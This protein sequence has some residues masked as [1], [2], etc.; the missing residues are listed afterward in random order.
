MLKSVIFIVFFTLF[1]ISCSQKEF[2][3][4]NPLG[5]AFGKPNDTDPLGIGLKPTLPSKDTSFP[6]PINSVS[7]Q[8]I[9]ALPLTNPKTHGSTFATPYSKPMLSSSPMQSAP[10]LA[11]MPDLFDRT[12]DFF[13]LMGANGVTITIWA[14]AAGNWLWGYSLNGSP[15]L[16]GLRIWRFVFLPSG[17]VMIL[18]FAT[19]TTCINTYGI[20]IIHANC[21]E[22]NP[23]QRFILN[24][25]TNGAVQIYN[26]TANTCIQTPLDDVFN[27]DDFGEIALT[28]CN[29]SLD[30][31]WYILPPPLTSNLYE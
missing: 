19:K 24:P 6:R 4:E 18:N 13:V 17:E 11:N 3:K 20:G 27:G 25:M 10:R 5:Q 31:Q 29:N 23:Y 16:G 30:Q 12:S 7:K 21:D 9:E 14:T 1:F 2:I 8:S 26:K 15:D 22:K 28:K